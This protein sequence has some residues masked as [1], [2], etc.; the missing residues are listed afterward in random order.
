MNDDDL[1]T[2]KSFQAVTNYCITGETP[3]GVRPAVMERLADLVALFPGKSEHEPRKS[4]N[5][6][7]ISGC[8]QTIARRYYSR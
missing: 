8:S 7:K 1:K 4:E 6:V 2:L 3:E 5:T